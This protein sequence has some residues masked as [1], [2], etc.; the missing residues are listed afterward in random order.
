MQHKDNI[1]NQDAFL[2]FSEIVFEEFFKRNLD[3]ENYKDITRILEHCGLNT[4][5]LPEYLEMHAIEDIQRVR[6]NAFDDGGLSI[7]LIHFVKSNALTCW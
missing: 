6:E 3:I 7:T 5:K 1:R 4:E 2:Q